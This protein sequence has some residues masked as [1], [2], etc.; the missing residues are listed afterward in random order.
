[1]QTT[2]SLQTKRAKTTPAAAPT[3]HMLPDEPLLIPARMLQPVQRQ[4]RRDVQPSEYHAQLAELQWAAVRTSP[5]Q[6]NAGLAAYAGF[7]SRHSFVGEAGMLLSDKEWW[8]NGAVLLGREIQSD[9]WHVQAHPCEMQVAM[10][11]VD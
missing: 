8:E 3:W 1:M 9:F 10:E 2:L 11:E 6:N 4:H 7:S 5:V